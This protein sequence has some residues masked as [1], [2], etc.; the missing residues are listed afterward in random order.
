[1]NHKGEMILKFDEFFVAMLPRQILKSQVVLINLLF[2]C[3][4]EEDKE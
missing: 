4:Y 2:P 1:M 3:K